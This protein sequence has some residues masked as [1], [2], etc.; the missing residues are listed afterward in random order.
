MRQNFPDAVADRQKAYDILVESNID[1]TM[2]R[3]P[4]IEQTNERRGVLV[5]VQD[6]PGE[7]IST[8]DL[9]DFVIGQIEDVS[10]L[11]RAPFVASYN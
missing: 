1:W 6:C 3:L 5:D 10:Y 11:R 7:K 9:A 8:T 2:I 4:W